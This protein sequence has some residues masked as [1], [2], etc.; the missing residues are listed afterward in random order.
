MSAALSQATA[1]R[2]LTAVLL[3]TGALLSGCGGNA[4]PPAAAT[5][6]PTVT[7]EHVPSTHLNV[8]PEESAVRFTAAAL[9]GN[10]QVEGSYGVLGGEVVLRPEEGQLRI[11]ALVLIDTPSVTVGNA[12]IDEALRLGMETTAYPIA[13]FD[14]ASTTL[15]PVTEEPVAFT[16][17]GTLTLHGQ[18]QAVTM[19]VDPATVIDNHLNARATMAIDLSDFGIVLPEAVVSSAIVLDVTLIADEDAP[20]RPAPSPTPAAE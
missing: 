3:I 5:P 10:I 4:A 20:A 7:P 16:L 2:T 8:I 6:I 9:G 12:V 17:A 1:M 13:I 19:Q 18:T 15:V 14:A 11:R